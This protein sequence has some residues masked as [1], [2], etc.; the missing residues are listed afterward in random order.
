LYV[1]SLRFQ[2]LCLS[3][4]AIFR[5]QSNEQ[6]SL[7]YQDLGCEHHLVQDQTSNT[8]TI[9]GLT[10]VGFA[11]WMTIHILAY[12]NEESKRFEKVVLAMP[13]DADGE[14]VD[15]KPERLPKQISRH[16]LPERRDRKFKRLLDG[17]MKNFFDALELSSRRKASITGPPL[18]RHSFTSQSRSRPVEIH[19]IRTSPTNSKAKPLER[20][21]NSY[22]GA[23]SA[24]ESLSN[25]DL[26]KLERDRAPY[27]ALPGNGKVCTEGSNLNIPKLGRTSSTCRTREPEA[28]ETLE[29]R[30][31]RTKSNA[32]QNSYMPP[33]RP[34]GKSYS[35]ST[36]P[37][38][39]TGGSKYS[40]GPS[41]TASSLSTP[42]Q[43]SS[44]LP[45]RS[46]DDR[47]YRRGTGEEARFTGE[48]NS[49]KDTEEAQ[50][51]ESERTG[52]PRETSRHSRGTGYETYARNY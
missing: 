10:P 43:L 30:H 4:L 14:M 28:V 37:D 52:R 8:P 48:F 7:L 17:A 34:G 6:I 25:E 26:V 33:P 45:R 41:S 2:T 46:R 3:S 12:P 19:Q 29:A 1:S 27:T 51:G 36:L 31:H 11:Q 40:R 38:I 9:P 32:S 35:N 49:P 18:S 47:Q 50:A 22:T 44:F 39:S 24:S 13:I 23:P 5:T 15:G 16:L 21:R 20:E 42:S